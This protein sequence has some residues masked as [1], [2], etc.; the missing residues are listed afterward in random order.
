LGL[1]KRFGFQVYNTEI[2]ERQGVEFQRYLV[3]RFILIP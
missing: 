2:V 1:F 3:E